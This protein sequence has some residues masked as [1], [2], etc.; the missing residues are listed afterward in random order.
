[1]RNGDHDVIRETW[2]RVA[3]EMGVPYIIT[4][5]GETAP[6]LGPHEVFA[7]I[8]DD[9][10]HLPDK[11]LWNCRFALN[12]D[13]D[14]VFQCFRDTYISIPRLIDAFERIQGEHVVGNFYFHNFEV[15][16]PCGGSG[17]WMSADFMRKLI[18]A[19]TGGATSEDIMVG[20]VMRRNNIVGFHDSRYDHLTFRGGV[21]KHN[22]NITNHLWSWYMNWPTATGLSWNHDWLRQEQRKELTGEWTEHDIKRRAKYTEEWWKT[23]VR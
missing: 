12:A 14:F 21:S 11:T 20:E 17:Y 3:D 6:A 10:N 23:C 7:P 22:N 4:V 13:F 5:G 2:G 8:I 19:G 16:Y 15:D 9:W 1:M 18:D